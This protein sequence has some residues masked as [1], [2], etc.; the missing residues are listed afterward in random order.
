MAHISQASIQRDVRDLAVRIETWD[1][2]T[3]TT[4][5]QNFSGYE[6]RYVQGALTARVDNKNAFSM[7]FG[8]Y[9]TNL[10]SSPHIPSSGMNSRA[11]YIFADGR[12]NARV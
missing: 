1:H 12:T 7:G 8:S 6:N 3:I 10:P 11:E 5:D 9:A 2:T 4:T